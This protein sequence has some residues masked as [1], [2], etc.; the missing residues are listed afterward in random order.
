MLSLHLPFQYTPICESEVTRG[1]KSSTNAA[2][3]SYPPSRR[4]RD[5]CGSIMGSP[6]SEHAEGVA[7][8]LNYMVKYQRTSWQ[9]QEVFARHRA[10]FCH[11]R[12]RRV[13]EVES[14]PNPKSFPHPF[15]D[16]Q[17]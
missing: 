9:C 12:P 4:Y 3:A 11:F 16:F 15:N 6:F 1:R 5:G 13:R 17:I 7:T 8:T 14:Q 2:R 10:W